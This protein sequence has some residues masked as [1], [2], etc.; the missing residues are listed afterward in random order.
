MAGIFCRSAIVSMS[1]GDCS[2]PKAAVESCR[3]RGRAGRLAGEQRVVD[4]IDDVD[5]TTP[6]DSGVVTPR[7]PAGDEHRRRRI[8]RHRWLASRSILSAAVLS[9][10]SWRRRHQRAA[11]AM[12][13]PDGA[14]KQIHRLIERLVAQVGDVGDDAELISRSRSRSRLAKRSARRCPARRCLSMAI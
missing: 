1:P 3:C 4:M 14:A 8:E 10:L 11:V 5:S 9:S 13:G 6:D 2:R 7:F 12:A